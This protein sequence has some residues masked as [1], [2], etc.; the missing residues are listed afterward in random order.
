MW[1]KRKS[2]ESNSTVKGIIKIKQEAKV[3]WLQIKM[4]KQGTA[5]VKYNLVVSISIF[6]AIAC[7]AFTV[8]SIFYA[9][10]KHDATQKHELDWLK[11]F[12]FSVPL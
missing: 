8:I 1:Q 11:L 12:V 4:T 2:I 10:L 3:K 5:A 7:E 6:L 9:V